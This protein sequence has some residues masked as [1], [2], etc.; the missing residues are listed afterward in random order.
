VSRK[1]L[2]VQCEKYALAIEPV[3]KQFKA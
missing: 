2:A 1:V 3:S